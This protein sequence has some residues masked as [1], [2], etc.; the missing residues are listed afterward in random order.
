MSVLEAGEYEDRIAL[1]STWATG[2]W[3]A[4]LEFTS[5]DLVVALADGGYERGPRAAVS[6]VPEPSSGLLVLLGTLG[7]LRRRR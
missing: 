5:A 4:D 2:N 1:D 6:S 3:N 7:V